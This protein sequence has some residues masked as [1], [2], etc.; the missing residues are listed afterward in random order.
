[1]SRR[2]AVAVRHTGGKLRQVPPLPS[3]SEVTRLRDAALAGLRDPVWGS[4]LGWLFLSGKVSAVQFA[5]GKR[6][7]E[8]AADYSA[9]CCGP[10]QVRSAKL[11]P[12]G[13]TSPDPDSPKG[14]RE[15][16]R[17]V[18]AVEQYLEGSELLKRL[19]GAAAVAVRNVC[20][21]G[22]MPVGFGELLALR[23]GLAVLAAWQQRKQ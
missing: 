3:P 12:A 6:W 7:V 13:G 9:A 22:R 23:R 14:L 8:L 20:E 1:M 19:G 21:Q 15:A 18:L 5:A 10:K 17:H 11:D 16:R 4:T 2:K